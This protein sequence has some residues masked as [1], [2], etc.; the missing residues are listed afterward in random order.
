[1]RQER[2]YSKYVYFHSKQDV[3]LQY[4]NFFSFVAL[5]QKKETICFLTKNIK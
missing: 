5:W 2:Q 3:Y 1:M 4:S